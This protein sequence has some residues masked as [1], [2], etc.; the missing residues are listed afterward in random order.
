GDYSIDV[1][2]D[3][4]LRDHR[5]YIHISPGRQAATAGNSAL[6]TTFILK[7]AEVMQA[8]LKKEAA[9][10]PADDAAAKKRE[11]QERARKELMDSF[12]AGKAALDAKKYDEAVT[13]LTKA[14]EV[15]PKQAAVWSALADDYMGMA[16]GQ[17]SSEAA[18]TYD[19]AIAAF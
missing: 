17:K 18:P 7:P 15:D 16:R 9:A 6:G 13:N 14:S 10:A 5:D 4:Q 19:K 3:G 8:E 11:E 1:L 12:A 2:V